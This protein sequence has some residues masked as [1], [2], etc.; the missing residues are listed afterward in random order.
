MSAPEI[1]LKRLRVCWHR[2]IALS[3]KAS[4]LDI[5]KEAIAQMIL[6]HN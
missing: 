6:Y 2:R 3:R 5:A 4:E 1:L